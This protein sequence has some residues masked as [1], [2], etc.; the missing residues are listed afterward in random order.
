MTLVVE[1][2]DGKLAGNMTGSYGTINEAPMVDITLEKDSFVFSVEAEGPQGSVMIK[3]TM[4]VA[5]DTMTG[6]L[7][8]PDMGLGGTWEAAKQ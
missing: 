3:F 4:K 8:I 6:Q 5:G 2:K 1:L 7:E